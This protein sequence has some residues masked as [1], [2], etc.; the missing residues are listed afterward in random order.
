MGA[1]AELF[2]AL[3]QLRM[4]PLP[5]KTPEQS[6]RELCRTV[7]G[8]IERVH[9]DFKEKANRSAVQL[10]DAD[11]QNLAKAISGFANGAGGVL[12]WGLEDGT[13]S[14][15]PIDNVSKFVDVILQMGHQVT[16][17]SVKG[18]DG[19]FIPSDSNAAAGFAL[20][21][22]PES[23]LPPHRAILSIAKVQNHYF[24]R[25]GSSFAVATHSQLEDM[26]GRRPRPHL[27]LSHKAKRGTS[28]GVGEVEVSITLSLTNEGRGIARYPFLDVDISP[29]HGVSGF[30][31]DG[32]GNFGLP[33]IV[34]GSF[35]GRADN[36]L[37]DSL[38]FGSQ[39]GYVIH[40]GVTH[41]VA[42]ANAMVFVDNKEKTG[43]LT[44]NFGIAAE[45]LPLE[46]GQLCISADEL[47]R[48]ANL[49]AMA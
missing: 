8:G 24:V 20:I 43:D 30:G 4:L 14:S 31:I 47:I 49:K 36:R 2:Q 46:R 48:I 5:E 37:Y 29:P 3:R 17:P 9:F 42:I 45:G 6:L 1:A 34:R 44:I 15:K 21:H 28:Y 11:K 7:L 12:I 16:A 40:S 39:D 41:S 13:L 32:N 10:D 19:D 33:V 26:F 35:V 27:V 22:V 18:I 23:D 38:K 25:S